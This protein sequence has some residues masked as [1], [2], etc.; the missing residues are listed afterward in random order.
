VPVRR[1]GR[2]CDGRP[3]C[4]LVGLCDAEQPRSD[5][6]TPIIVITSTIMA[7]ADD[8]KWVPEYSMYFSAK[9]NTYAKPNAWTGDWEY[10]SAGETSAAGAAAVA[11]QVVGWAMLE[12]DG[13]GLQDEDDAKRRDPS[14]TS[15][16][17]KWNDPS[18]YPHQPLAPISS[19]P[20]LSSKHD[21]DDQPTDAPRSDQI[22]RLVA[23]KSSILTGAERVAV[24]DSREDGFI[25]GRDKNFHP[26]IRLKEMEVSKVHATLFWGDGK[27][28]L[29]DEE[30]EA[31]YWLVDNGR[32]RSVN[33]SQ[34][35]TTDMA[36]FLFRI[37]TWY[38]PSRST[39]EN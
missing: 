32:P 18:I 15:A 13:K 22:L 12:E 28:S 17:T 36:R 16:S 2:A 38:L 23:L 31:G 6:H 19:T 21:Q 26:R 5:L 25:I 7:T 27:G 35:A 11:S 37:Y 34:S 9:S 14:A 10:Q 1:H 20:V 24:I 8:W 3:V 39:P 4:V 29:D 33:K 30:G